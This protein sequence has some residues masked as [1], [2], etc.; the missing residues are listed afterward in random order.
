[1]SEAQ[2]DPADRVAAW[3]TGVGT[4]ALAFM[5]TW[6]FGNRLTALVLEPPVGP[7]LAMALAVVVGGL[8]AVTQGRRLAARFE[9]QD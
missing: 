3:A 1:M 7:I 5:L 4:G 6:L 8:V 2:T 9:I